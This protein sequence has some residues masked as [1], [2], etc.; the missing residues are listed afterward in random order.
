MLQLI[1]A[2]SRE[3]S[4]QPNNGADAQNKPIII[5][6]VVAI[7]TSSFQFFLIFNGSLIALYLYDRLKIT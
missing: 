1:M 7:V 3:Y 4:D 6:T 2:P 5:D